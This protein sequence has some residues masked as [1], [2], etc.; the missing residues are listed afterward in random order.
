[1]KKILTLTYLIAL[2][3][4]VS[5]GAMATGFKIRGGVTSNNYELFNPDGSSWVAT[6]EHGSN[7]GLKL[8]IDNS[9]YFD[10]DFARGG[11][12][13]NGL[14]Y[15]G[16]ITS[17]DLAVNYGNGWIHANGNIGDIYIGLRMGETKLAP[18]NTAAAIAANASVINFKTTGLVLG[19]REAFPLD[20]GGYLTLSLAL[21]AMNGQYDVST[22]NSTNVTT[23]KADRVS[24][25]SYG[26]GYFHA[27]TAD[28]SFSVDYKGQYHDYF[29]DSGLPSE[30][31]LRER[32][33]GFGATLFV[34]F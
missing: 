33:N 23:F 3:A 28:V 24:Y 5:Q 1:M 13:Y 18:N 8:P 15:T 12:G 10:V 26:V 14:A 20:V 29:F 21:G 2:V 25:Y 9:S 30:Y 22:I 6:T 19:G 4:L 11:G 27:I 31:K 32:L 34:M 16:Q 17:S 7:V